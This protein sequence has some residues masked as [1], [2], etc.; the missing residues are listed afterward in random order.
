MAKDTFGEDV[1]LL[2]RVLIPFYIVR[3]AACCFYGASLIWGMVLVNDMRH[4]FYHLW[5][6][7]GNTSAF[8]VL[9]TLIGFFVVIAACLILDIVCV[10]KRWRRT[11][12][13]RFF[14]IANV[15]QTVV[16]LVI[17]VLMLVV[18]VRRTIDI[19]VSSVI[20]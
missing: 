8:Q 4:R 1:P 9:A 13:H 10:I 5:T 7:Y 6:E 12:S 19:A 18:G 15:I 3:I 20:L 11:L 16:M 14:L 2:K 17:F